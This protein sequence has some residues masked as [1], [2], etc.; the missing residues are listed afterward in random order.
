MKDMMTVVVPGREDRDEIE[1]PNILCEYAGEQ[2]FEYEL[3]SDPRRQRGKYAAKLRDGT[4][5]S[6]ATVVDA[7]V[8]GNIARFVNEGINCED[9]S[10]SRVPNCTFIAVGRRVFLQLL[11]DVPS[12][13]E[14]L[15]NYGYRY[16]K[17][18]MRA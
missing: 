7:S 10:Q 8:M 17:A 18:E 15:V 6:P 14:I 2:L 9:P 13:S 4:V 5:F 3:D 1:F 12:G 11:R 16:R